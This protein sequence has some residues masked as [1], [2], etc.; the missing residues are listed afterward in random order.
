[1]PAAAT[2]SDPRHDAALR[3]QLIAFNLTPGEYD[4][5]VEHLGRAPNLAE[6]GMFS[7]LW[8]EHCCYKHSRHLLKTLP[9]EGPRILQGPGE[10]AGVIDVGDGMA[11]AFKIESHNHPTAVEPFQGATTGVGGILRDI[12]TMNARPVANLNALRFGPQTDAHNRMLFT[13][14]VE[15]IAHYG[16]CVGVPT[17][18]G[19]VFFD[20]GYTGNPLVNA[21]AIG[22]LYGDELMTSAA[23]GLGN[24]VLYVGSATGRDGMGGAAF[25]SR[26][27]NEGSM[28]DRPAVQ[29][30]DPFT[31]KL[32]IESC[33]EA[34]ATGLVV[35]AQ[36]M[37]AAGLTCSGAEMAAKG[38][39]GMHIDLDRVPAREPDMTPSDYLM[40]ESQERMLMVLNKGQ[41]QPVIDIF[42]KWGVPAAIVGEVTATG[43]VCFTQRGQVV[44]DV[45]APLLTDLAPLY[46][47]GIV[48]QEPDAARQRR[49]RDPADGISDLKASDVAAWLDRLCGSTNIARPVGV[50]RQYDRHVQNNT[51]AASD[52]H[53]AGLIQLRDAQNRWSGKALAA[54]TD[55][56]SRYV[57]LNPKTG[58]MS[59]VA[60]A[61]RNITC[62]GAEPLGISDNLNFGDPEKPE[63]YYQLYQSIAGIRDACLALETPVTGG[64][65]SLYNDHAGTSIPPAPVIAMIGLLEDATKT[66][67]AVFKAPGD[68]LVLLGQFSPTLAG[69]EYQQLCAGE[70]FGEPPAIDMQ[71]EK[72]TA[73]LVRTLIQAGL[74]RSASDV[75]VGGLLITLVEGVFAD[76][77]TQPLGDTPSACH[78]GLELSGLSALVSGDSEASSSSMRRDTLLFGETNGCYVLSLSP[79]A[80]EAVSTQAQTAG[81][82]LIRLGH[83]TAQPTLTLPELEAAIPLASAYRH[84]S[85]TLDFDN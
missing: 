56:N 62:T 63:I 46:D 8:S 17:I 21:M 6:L 80:V 64:N 76:A 40:S 33:L 66:A 55:C 69:S 20:A 77:A 53:G 79:D 67:S 75:S 48:P 28:A 83:I 34:F 15:G 41:E 24:P 23:A 45:P 10:N 65:V 61:A 84:W 71:A 59:A 13:R 50:F 78:W 72:S 43:N 60:E 32:L 47:P 52:Q 18:G 14:A 82:P 31:E 39:V 26:E 5:I 29:V 49:E 42:E 44:A 57:Q 27:L 9:T 70:I 36:D 4:R 38:G 11:V 81:V 19:E 35:A 7:V 37:G 12:F 74:V 85:T 54:T 51:L 3:D 22:M 2:Q 68:V 30:G 58:S 16:N 25:A 1:M 73:Q